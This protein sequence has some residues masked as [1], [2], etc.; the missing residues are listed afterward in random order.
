MNI[1]ELIE[2]YVNQYSAERNLAEHTVKNKRNMFN[3]LLTFL[4]NKDL[5]LESI[6]EYLNTMRARNVAPVSIK[7]EIRMIKAFTTYLFKKGI[8]TDNWGKLIVIPK[9]PRKPEALVSSE[10]AEEIIIRGTTPGPSDHALHRERKREMRFAMRFMLRTGIRIGELLKIKGNDLYLEND[11]PMELVHSK[12]GNLDHQPLP[13]DM[14]DELKRRINR[15]R[16]FPVVRDSMNH[17]LQKGAYMSK[18]Q[19]D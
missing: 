15:K 6:N 5:T 18:P 16:V 8:I 9:V 7:D 13:M 2:T 19:N 1:K 11:S 14:L 3:R 12:G 4:G 17:L 10:K